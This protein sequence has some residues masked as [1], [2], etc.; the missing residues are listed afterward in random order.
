MLEEMKDIEMIGENI[1]LKSLNEDDVGHN[2]LEWMNDPEVTRFLEARESLY[3]MDDLKSYVIDI[4]K[5]KNDFLFGIY[6][7]NKDVHIGNVK[8]GRIN[9]K[10]RFGDIGIVI[11]VKKYWGK[12]IGTEVVKE[13]T[14][15][16]FNELNLKKLIAGVH[17]INV[18]SE[19]IFIKNGYR[20]VSCHKSNMFVDGNFIDGYF[21][22]LSREC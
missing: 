3:T 21:Y 6:E 2:Y 12:G 7:K 10:Q 15:Y 22:E 13:A 4:K 11:G 1:K 19:K 18:G 8:I 14:K 17:A 16:A 9:W 5:S 20:K